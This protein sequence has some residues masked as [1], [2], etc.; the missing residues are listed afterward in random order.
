M[1]LYM[2]QFAYTPE[3]WSGLIKNPE[4]R[5]KVGRELLEKAG[6]RLIS[7]YYAFGEYDGLAIFEA[8]D[9]TAATAVALAIASSGGFKATKTTVLLTPETAMEAMRKAASAG[10]AYRAPGR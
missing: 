9:E 1:S 4:D 10:G 2:F 5:S 8:P 3:A 7:F 6:C